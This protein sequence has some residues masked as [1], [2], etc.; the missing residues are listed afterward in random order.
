MEGQDVTDAFQGAGKHGRIPGELSLYDK[1]GT[2]RGGLGAVI[3]FINNDQIRMA[4]QLMSCRLMRKS[5]K[6]ECFLDTM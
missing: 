4:C 2:K 1:F 3:S 6:G 5:Y